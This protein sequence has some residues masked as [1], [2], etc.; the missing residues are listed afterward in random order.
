MYYDKETRVMV[1][2]SVNE[3]YTQFLLRIYSIQQVVVLTLGI[4]ATLLNSLRPDITEFLT[5]EGVHP[6]PRPPTKTNHQVNPRLFLVINV[7][8]ETENKIR[9]IKAV[10]K[11]ASRGLHPRTFICMLGEKTSIK[12]AI[13]GGIFQAG[14]Y[15][16]MMLEPLE[17][18][19]LSSMEEYYE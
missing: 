5:S 6:P 15:N 14:K 11:P 17:E 2:Q 1:N 13:L 18:Y 7:D 4:T 10:M 19:E 16:Y 12:M 3:F 9:T 8:V